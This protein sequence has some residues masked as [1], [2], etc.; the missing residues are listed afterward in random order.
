M[1]EELLS[2][3][4]ATPEQIAQ[5][6]QRSGFEELGLLGQALMQA[7]APAPR[8]TS[9]LGRLGQAA[10]AYTQAPR[11]TMDTLLQDLL[12]KQQIQDM[13]RKREQQLRSEAARQQFAN[14]FA[15]TTP[16]AALAAPG[17]V[18]PTAARAG[19]IGQTPPLDRNQLFAQSLN[20]DLPGDL[21]Q[22]AAE[23]FKAT[24][25]AETKLPTSAQEFELAQQNP[26]FAAFL[27]QKQEASGTKIS[28]DMNKTFGGTLDKN[29]ESY[30][31]NGLKARNAI[32]NI[33]TM[34]ALLDEGVRTGFGQET[35][36]RLNQAAQL[37]NPNYKAKQTAGQEN[38]IA[39]SNEIILP[40]VKQLGVNP[41]D[42]DLNFIVKGSPTLSKSVEGNKL[43]LRALDIKLQ[44]D[45][46]LQDFVTNWQDQNVS[47]IEQSP[48]RANTELRKQVL[49]L[50]KTH[51]LWTEASEQLRQQ[52]S[53]ITG[54]QSSSLT[55][56]SPFS[57]K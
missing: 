42:A 52:Y 27:K 12:R 28:I 54:G 38:F 26:Q 19:M 21:R 14:M 33:R 43:L 30:F 31:D 7:G 34:S 36:N 46:F 48:V 51:P 10:G 35:I 2:L 13:Q 40:Q 49:A 23:A 56:G 3:L 4:G 9:T 18:G 44:R 29:L 25:P 50:T 8:G 47:L 20:P 57:R 55:A 37:F 15:P 39:L 41:T 24:A 53:Q 11:Q 17:R 16:Q 22:A 45:A 32:P 5:A 6:R 1:N